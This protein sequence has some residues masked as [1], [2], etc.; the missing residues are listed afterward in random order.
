MIDVL[1]LGARWTS[2]YHSVTNTFADALD[3]DRFNPRMMG[4]LGSRSI[5]EAA[6]LREVHRSARPLILVGYAH[7]AAIVGDVAAEFGG[8]GSPIVACALVSD[9]FRPRGQVVGNDP[10][11]YGILGEREV[12][13][14]PAYWAAARGD[15]TTALVDGSSLRMVP[16]LFEYFDLSTD[17]AVIDWRRRLVDAAIRE[18]LAR[19]PAA[20]RLWYG[21][22]PEHFMTTANL[23]TG[24][25]ETNYVRLGHVERLAQTI[26]KEIA[27]RN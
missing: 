27:V 13:A 24:A 9:P 23:L 20:R 19:Y 6:V 5:V 21:R 12:S 15:L 2:V 18:Q 26:N 8:G 7:G 1:I 17:E 10:G 14:V 4:C 16:E 3:R 22:R 25:N 11:G